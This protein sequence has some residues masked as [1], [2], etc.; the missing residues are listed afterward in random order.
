[1]SLE[2]IE[3][4][5]RTSAARGGP[6]TAE[7]RAA[8]DYFSPGG[9]RMGLQTAIA[10][11][12]LS[13]LHSVHVDACLQPG[14]TARFLERVAGPRVTNRIVRDIPAARVYNHP[15]LF[16]A[17][18]YRQR[19]QLSGKDTAAVDRMLFR[20]YAWIARQCHSE[21]VA[22]PPGASLEL[23]GDRA[24][25]VIEQFAPPRPYERA[26]AAQE[27]ARFPGWAPDGVTRPTL[28]DQRVEEE[29]Q[30]AD[31]IWVPSQHL[32]GI[33]QELGAD[34]RKFR[35]IPYPITALKRDS[36]ARDTQDRRGRLRVVF[37]G[38]LMLEKGVQYIYQAL[39][40]RPRLPIEM[41][42][43]GPVNL[44]PLGVQR[45]AEVGTVHGP[46]PRS[47]LLREFCDADALLFPSLSEGSA[48]VTLEA[49]AL[50]LPVVATSEAG[51]PAS[52][53][54]I[55]TRD[56]EAIGDAIEALADEPAR[57]EQLAMTGL[58]EA[59]RRTPASYANS[60]LSSLR[61]EAYSDAG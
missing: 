26:I 15:Q 3:L 27:L 55:P 56:P 5:G 4:A 6:P 60:I 36:L 19:Q 52:A 54:V 1:M 17:A 61:P 47:Q 20:M 41:H 2:K 16:A 18:R 22:G 49:T 48:L 57:L 43:Y 10:L 58:A 21:A 39:R 45:L 7:K 23:F 13:L 46:V 32:V 30:L 53:M 44:T 25:R 38:T 42:F 35:V 24:Y 11:D 50:G 34:P 9:V 12:K 37:A 59:A 40:T 31:R 29:W 14:I 51:A 33:S 28:R 8:F